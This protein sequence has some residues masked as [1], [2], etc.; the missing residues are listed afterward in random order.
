M[1]KTTK[2]LT[3]F[4]LILLFAFLMNV[5]VEEKAYAAGSSSATAEA[6]ELDTWYIDEI[7][8]Y[9]GNNK[10]YKSQ[11]FKFKTSGNSDSK[12][13]I[14]VYPIS[15]VDNSKW[16]DD[17]LDSDF[18]I[19]V[20][21]KHITDYI[22]DSHEGFVRKF[23]EFKP[24][25]TYRLKIAGFLYGEDDYDE[26]DGSIHYRKGSIRY[27]IL[28]KEV[29]SE[30]IV[31]STSSSS[32]VTLKPNNSY[33]ITSEYEYGKTKKNYFNF[34]TCSRDNS[35]YLIDVYEEDWYAYDPVLNLDGSFY[36]C[37]TNLKPGYTKK[38]RV[39]VSKVFSHSYTNEE[40]KLA[41]A[42]TSTTYTLFVL[43]IPDMP[44]KQSITSLT[45]GSKKFTVKF[46]SN[47]IRTRY[48]IAYKLTSSS[49]WK[50][51]TTTSTSKTIKG[52]TSGKKYYV[53]VRSQR[54]IDGKY[55]S[56]QW[57]VTKT[58]KVK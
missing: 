8:T 41:K 38:F 43:E 1:R 56:G 13:V 55:H 35:K 7:D 25:T 36:K 51:A 48:Q 4:L 28:I 52:L 32:P 46:K 16:P 37:N 2:A 3:G 34:K 12:Y 24:N 31:A 11:F 40:K 18:L 53:K 30:S 26:D 57:S 6:L 20:N 10:D 42:A 54:K 29:K 17:N 15:Y 58:V 47:S 45:A 33:R 39:N 49:T 14:V 9:H 22:S 44:S 50:F 27:K 23:Y 19:Y 21:G 5:S